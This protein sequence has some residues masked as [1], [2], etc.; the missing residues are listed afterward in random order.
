MSASEIASPQDASLPEI[1][2]CLGRPCRAG[3]D[4]KTFK[5]SFEHD[6]DCAADGVT[7]AQG[8][9]A[10]AQDFNAFHP[11]Y[12]QG[13]KIDDRI[14]NAAAVDEYRN[15][16]ASGHERPKDAEVVVVTASVP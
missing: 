16:A 11:R 14:G 9:G 12:R 10:V 13:V 7:A 2:A 3:L 1:A 8:R 15:A 6:V 5:V 4:L